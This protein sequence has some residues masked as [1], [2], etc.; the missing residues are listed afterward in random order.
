MSSVPDGSLAEWGVSGSHGAA[1]LLKEEAG[2]FQD[3]PATG[4]I[5]LPKEVEDPVG[6]VGQTRP[7]WQE[8]VIP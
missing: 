2:V 8:T 6:A 5:R 7:P 1:A 4:E 3:H